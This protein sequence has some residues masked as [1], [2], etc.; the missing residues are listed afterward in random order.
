MILEENCQCP[1][2]LSIQVPLSLP[3]SLILPDA[4]PIQ[5]GMLNAG[6]IPFL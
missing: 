1:Q 5:Q 4:N 3:A 6:P 2:L